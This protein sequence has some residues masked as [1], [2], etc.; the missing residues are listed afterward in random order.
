NV[1]IMKLSEYNELARALG[2]QQE[3]I[4]K[5]DEMLLIP[6]VVSQ[7][8]EFKNGDY[9]KNIEVI[10]GDWTK[11][12]YV[13]KTVDNLVLPHDTEGINIA[14]QDHVYDEI[15]LNSNLDFENIIQYRTY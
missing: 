12:F 2:Y 11:T 14:I 8:Q 4:E 7:K 3:T 13:K 5:E 15:P 6:G 10:Q 1:N 9:K